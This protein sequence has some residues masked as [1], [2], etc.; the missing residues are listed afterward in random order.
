MRTLCLG[1]AATFVV[2]GAQVAAADGCAAPESEQ[3][4]FWVGKWD[5]ASAKKPDKKIANSLIEKLYKGCAVREN[6][7]PLRAPAAGGSLNSF[8]PDQKKWRQF[9][10]DSDGSVAE[11][12]GGWT[13]STMVLEGWQVQAGQPR[14]RKRMTFTPQPDG[15]VEQVGET[16]SDEGKSWKP[17]YDLIYRHPR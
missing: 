4:D 12:V 17:E 2:A 3:F 13:G 7:M 9:W 10:V 11:F 15:S 5:V 6:W 1:I 16:S 14:V 8:D